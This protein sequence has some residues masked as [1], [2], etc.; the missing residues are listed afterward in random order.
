MGS[1][2][3]IKSIDHDGIENTIEIDAIFV[4]SDTQGE[5]DEMKEELEK[6]IEKYK[7]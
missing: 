7:V 6:V 5:F 2:I 3:S 1:K 4:I